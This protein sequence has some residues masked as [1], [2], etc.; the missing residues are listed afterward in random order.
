MSTKGERGAVLQLE[1]DRKRWGE[2]AMYGGLQTTGLNK[3]TAD[4]RLK[5]LLLSTIMDT[6]T[7]GG[8]FV[9]VAT[10]DKITLVQRPDAEEL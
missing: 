2:T 7:N 5:N 3:E 6:V 1:I 8:T 9:L 4:M 10:A